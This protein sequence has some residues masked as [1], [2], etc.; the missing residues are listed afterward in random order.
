MDN[1]ME[2]KINK[3]LLEKDFNPAFC[4]FN[5]IKEAIKIVKSNYIH[6]SITK[7]IYPKIAEKYNTTIQRVE[8]GIRHI[9]EKSHMAGFKNFECICRIALEIK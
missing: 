2:E 8:R 3:Y 9:I 4:G 5:Y 1:I 6:L 7:D